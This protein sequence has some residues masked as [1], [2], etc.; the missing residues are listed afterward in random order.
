MSFFALYQQPP[1]F[2]GL[3]LLVSVWTLIW[4]G[5]ALWKAVGRKEKRW[6]VVLLVLNT[7]GILPI[8]YLLMKIDKKDNSKKVSVTKDKPIKVSK[9]TTKVKG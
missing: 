3:L 6:F 2:V 5:M 8:I 4:K 9:K 7:A 1:L